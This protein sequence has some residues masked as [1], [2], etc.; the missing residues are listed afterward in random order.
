MINY[1]F[2]G[3][4]AKVLAMARD[5]AARL[6]HNYLG[7]EHQLLGIAL[8]GEGVA[9]AILTN[10]GAD[11]DEI[12]EGVEALLEPGK[13]KVNS[14]EVPYTAPAV[15]VLKL[16][17]SEARDSDHAYV[18]TGHLLLGLLG[19]AKDVAAQVLNS[20]GIQLEEAR[21]EMLRL[22]PSE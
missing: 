18:G 7:T 19:E 9:A 11:L 10:L 5:E 6:N 4:V 12:R 17:M 22:G 2:T 1:S 8:E 21:A 3:R 15:K 20:V 16:A 14:G 13:S